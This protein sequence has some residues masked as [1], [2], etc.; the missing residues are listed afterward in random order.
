MSTDTQRRTEDYTEKLRQVCVG[1]KLSKKKW[2]VKKTLTKEQKEKAA[3][4]FGA[5]GKRI[6]ASKT[7]IDTANK[8]YSAVTAIFT[9]I[10]KEWEDHTLPYPE[11]G[12]RLM[13]REHVAE[14]DAKVS[15]Y[16]DRLDRAVA[17]LNDS[18]ASV[19]SEARDE[20]EDLFNLSDYPS[21][22]EGLFSIT[23][24][25]PSINADP[26][27][28]EISNGLY[29][30]EQQRIAARFD[31]ALEMAEQAFASEF[32]G[33]IEHLVGRLEGL[34]DGTAKQFHPSTTGNLEAFFERFRS[35]SIG[36]NADLERLVVDAQA[37]VRGIRP[38]W[39][40]SSQPLRDSVRSR[41]SQVQEQL[42]SMM[43]AR[44]KRA[45]SFED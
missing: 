29:Q 42:D 38:E 11:D 33:L 39:L 5:S 6:A 14:W 9:Q 41:M 40:E 2:G 45:I 15:Q 25:Y 21:S 36:S 3:K 20:L 32:Q 31:E 19:K 37:A 18:Y 24:E 26:S 35:L 12:I 28:A 1:C 27:L 43:V 13:K 22:L 10:T 44:P 30:R 4:V 8:K 17:T 16:Q 23:V 34:N 7:L